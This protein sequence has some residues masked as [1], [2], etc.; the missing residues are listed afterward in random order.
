MKWTVA[1]LALALS[2]G[3]ASAQLYGNS[4]NSLYGGLSG[5]GSN[6]SNHYVS[7]YVN[8]HGTYVQGHHTTNPNNTQL[9]NYTTRGNL[10]PYTGVIGTR[11]PG[12]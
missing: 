12:Y 10:N 8:S 7:P 11:R 2:S 9:D 3:F 1:T 5:T 4:N 6:P